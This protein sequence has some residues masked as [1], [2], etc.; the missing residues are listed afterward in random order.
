MFKNFAEAVVCVFPCV[1]QRQSTQESDA[2][3][4]VKKFCRGRAHKR[5][6]RLRLFK[7][8]AEAEH[9]GE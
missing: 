4:I 1:L 2:L 5:V 6:M 3:E 8:F 9:T 7:N